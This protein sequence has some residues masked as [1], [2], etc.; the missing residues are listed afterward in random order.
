MWSNEPISQ[1]REKEPIAILF[2]V[3]ISVLV[4]MGTVIVIPWVTS[5]L[6]QIIA[7]L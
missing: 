7:Q 5:S 4:I 3:L 6:S 1:N 2:P